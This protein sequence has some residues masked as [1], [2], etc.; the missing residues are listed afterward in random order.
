MNLKS[1]DEFIPVTD[2]MDEIHELHF[3]VATVVILSSNTGFSAYD[4]S[5]VASIASRPGQHDLAAELLD[6]T[7]E[8][9]LSAAG[10]G[11]THDQFHLS[12]S[13]L[14]A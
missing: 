2:S 5:G 11:T 12:V 9:A 14:R 1:T 6:S 3:F 8:R 4:S 7:F 10:A 13:A